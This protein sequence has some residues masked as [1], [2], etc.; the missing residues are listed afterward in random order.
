[1]AYPL[2]E[3]KTLQKQNIS[4]EPVHSRINELMTLHEFMAN[5]NIKSGSKQSETIMDMW[6][7]NKMPYVKQYPWDAPMFKGQIGRPFY[8]KSDDFPVSPDTL[9]IKKGVMHDFLA[10]MAH[11]VQYANVPQSVR[12]SLSA[13]NVAQRKKY[14]EAIYGFDK[15]PYTTGS[16]TTS[17][18]LFFPTHAFEPGEGGTGEYG[19]IGYS[20]YMPWY[21]EKQDVPVE[22][23]AH[24]I[25]QPLLEKRMKKAKDEDWKAENPWIF[26]LIEYLDNPKDWE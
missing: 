19:G 13:S 12:D 17:K 9:G 10:E 1:M 11:A 2:T 14:G 5:A 21:G 26:K 7:E 16:D 24:S 4:S 18:R 25:I 20:Q 6:V 23:Q 8:R 22:F 15:P 3:Q